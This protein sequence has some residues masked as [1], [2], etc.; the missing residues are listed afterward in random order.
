MKLLPLPL[1]L[2]LA[3]PV[4]PFSA[5]AATPAKPTAKPAA[6]TEAAKP[7][8]AQPALTPEVLLE[9]SRD[10]Q[11]KGDAELAQRL[12]QAA[13]VADPARPGSYVAL[14]ELYAAAGQGDYA[15]SCYD[16]ALE[17][18]P[19]DARATA[20]IAALSN[21]KATAANSP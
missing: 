21:A 20:A 3:L 1:L 14:G 19:A 5:L 9:Q 6:K 13:I 10:A 7:V 8:A 11:N 15:R 2:A 17:I 4:L 12:A 16:A 18:D